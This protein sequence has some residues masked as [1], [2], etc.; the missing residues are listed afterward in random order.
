M[1]KKQDNNIEEINLDQIDIE[2][3]K[4][5]GLDFTELKKSNILGRND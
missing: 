2:E 4:K 5:A 1:A 3:L